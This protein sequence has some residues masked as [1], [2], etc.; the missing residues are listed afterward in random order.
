MHV[1]TGKTR[2]DGWCSNDWDLQTNQPV[3]YGGRDIK[4][5]LAETLNTPAYRQ[6]QQRAGLNH[7]GAGNNP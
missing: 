5:A 7:S 2:R 3:N 4:T 1:G 6:Q